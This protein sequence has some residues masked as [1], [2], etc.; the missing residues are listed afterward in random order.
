MTPRTSKVTGYAQVALSKDGRY[1]HFTVHALVLSAFN[2]AQSHSSEC[3]HKDGCRTNNVLTNLE[4]GTR[5]QNMHD[6]YKHGT[7]IA[8]EWHPLASFT[9]EVVQWIR[10]STQTAAEI[11]RLLG[12]NTSTVCRARKGATYAAADRSQLV[13]LLA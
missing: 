6:Q 7:R 8:S 11:A 1:K 4:W 2:P 9:V 5:V 3:R 10:E 12:V 13:G